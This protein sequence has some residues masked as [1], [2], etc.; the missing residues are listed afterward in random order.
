MQATLQKIING[1]AFSRNWKR[2]AF[3][4]LLISLL[5]A[6]K[7]NSLEDIKEFS[8]DF[9]NMEYGKNVE[10]L[11][12]EE[13]LPTIRITAPT[14]NRYNAAPPEIPYT[15]FPDGMVLIVY[16]KQGKQE[17]ELKADKGKMTDNSDDLEVNGNVKIVNV[18]GETL[19][20]DILVWNKKDKK[21]RSE[22]NVEIFTNDEKIWGTGFEA[23]ENF[24]NYIIYNIKGVVKIKEGE[25]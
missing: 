10:I 17:S 12:T 18:K 20:T 9:M 8:A 16:D 13:G 15:E 2:V 14:A 3:L 5:T 19:K 22:G 1:N 21:I 23:D 11:F 6:C 4:I 25:L 7:K 24:T